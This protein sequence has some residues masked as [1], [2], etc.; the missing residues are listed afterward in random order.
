[1]RGIDNM[2]NN[3]YFTPYSTYIEV[4]DNYWESDSTFNI[5]FEYLFNDEKELSDG[6]MIAAVTSNKTGG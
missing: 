3:E 2:E 1:M 5:D 6:D 4:P